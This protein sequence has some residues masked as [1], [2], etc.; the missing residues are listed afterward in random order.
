M[1]DQLPTFL[2]RSVVVVGAGAVGCYYG[3]LLARAG[4][5]VTMLGRQAAVSAIRAQGL[6]VASDNETFSVSVRAE[7]DPQSARDASLVLVCVKS[8]DTTN[9]AQS[10]QPYLRSDALVLSL[11]NGVTNAAA[12]IDSLAQRVVPA[13]VYVATALEAPGKVRHFGGGAISIGSPRGRSVPLETLAEL[14]SLFGVAGIDATVSA[15]ITSVLWGKL[16]VNCAYNALSAITQQTYGQLVASD[17]TRRVMRAAI[18]EAIAVASAHQITLPEGTHERVM[19]V[20][21]MMPG[22]RSSTAQDLARSRPTEI[23]YLNGYITS[24]GAKAGIATPT[25]LTLFAL[26]KQIESGQTP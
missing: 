1:T 17:A 2:G 5:S 12:L 8:S 23:D 25:N 18:N 15:D 21:E 14:A 4:L 7:D 13:A 10:L 3:A 26:V 11:Q 6:R 24:E 16:V 22:Q 9:A 20:A 19:K